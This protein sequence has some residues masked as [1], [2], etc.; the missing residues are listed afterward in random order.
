[1][2]MNDI[3][4]FARTRACAATA[5][6]SPTLELRAG[7]DAKRLA[8]LGLT[9]VKKRKSKAGVRPAVRVLRRETV[10]H[11]TL[12][13]RSVA[14][15]RVRRVEARCGGKMTAGAAAE[16]S[17][18]RNRADRCAGCLPFARPARERMALSHRYAAAMG[19]AVESG[20][21]AGAERTGTD[22]GGEGDLMQCS[23]AI[24]CR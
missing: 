22:A 24:F 14:V 5:R 16:N 6:C 15:V 8:K 12:T 7:D 17:E 3:E 19:R 11:F 4:H 21:R 1:M 20:R 2:A 10:R 9:L 23:N 13:V 18:A